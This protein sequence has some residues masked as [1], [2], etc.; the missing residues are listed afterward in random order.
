M[1]VG[2]KT[3]LLILL[4]LSIPLGAEEIKA[5]DPVS[6]SPEKFTVILENNHL[7]VIEY[8]L[9]PGERDDWHTHPAK[10]SYVLESGTLRITTA[11]GES[12]VVDEHSG[13]ASWMDSLGLHYAENIGVT[14]VR[15]LLV[16]IKK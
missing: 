11:G 6:V 8:S 10:L 1:I 12:F 5:V 3:I 2:L 13:A 7:R 4:M 9:K 14:A 16:E 15:I